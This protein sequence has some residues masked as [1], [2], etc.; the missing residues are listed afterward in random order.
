MST[1]KSVAKEK[2]QLTQV[3]SACSTMQT[4]FSNLGS[5]IE[6]TVEVQ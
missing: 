2:G 1:I 5:V 6:A 3:E 4:A